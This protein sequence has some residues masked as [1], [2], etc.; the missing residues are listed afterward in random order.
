MMSTRRRDTS[1]PKGKVDPGETLPQTAVREVHEET[2][3]RVAL[4]VPLGAIEYGI[5]GGR[6]KSVSYWAA[7]A[8]EAVVEAGRFE[9]DHE[10]ESIE[11]VSI[12]N[13][14]K[15]LDYPGEIDILDLFAGLVE[16]G[17]HRSFALIALRHGHA[18]QPYEWDGPDASR[19]LSA[20]GQGEARSIVPTLA[21]FGPRVITSSTAERCLQTVAPLAEALGRR[22]KEDAGIS[23]D[24]YET[25]GGSV[26]E[27]V[28]KRVRKAR[29]AVL[30]SH[31]PVLPE[32]LHEIAL[33]TETPRASRMPRAGMLSP[34]EFSVVHLSASDPEAGILA[35]ESYGPSA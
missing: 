24:A 9:P 35:V 8:T 34:A 32:I 14:R 28:A 18:V 13:A 33:A 19:P 7:E 16:T 23:Q 29:S 10:V 5:S 21:A 2:G 11:W 30:C 3:L 27:T 15:R 12:P 20:R 17:S 25:D 26:R 4:G 1:L 22:V 31:S 6:R